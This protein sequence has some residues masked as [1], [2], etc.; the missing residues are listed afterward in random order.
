MSCTSIREQSQ[1]NLLSP[2]RAGL[3]AGL[4]ESERRMHGRAAKSTGFNSDVAASALQFLWA[5]DGSSAEGAVFDYYGVW[6][7]RMARRDTAVVALTHA[8]RTP[9]WFYN[10]SC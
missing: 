7:L 2:R 1:E 9:L 10:A 6:Q 3:S 5:G 8:H 4:L